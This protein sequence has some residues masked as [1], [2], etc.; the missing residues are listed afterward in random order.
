MKR[1]VIWAF[2]FVVLVLLVAQAIESN[3]DELT[4]TF[5]FKF[6]VPFTD[7]MFQTAAQLSVA[8]YFAICFVGGGFL[9][10]LLSLVAVI[11]S[12]RIAKRSRRE[13]EDAND[14]LER[15]RGPAE[16]DEVYQADRLE[17]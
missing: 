8:S 17:T 16:D 7:T 4:R 12:N 15:L 10:M 1:V 9:V 3:R 14:E 6:Q 5:P 11:K 2:L 13:L